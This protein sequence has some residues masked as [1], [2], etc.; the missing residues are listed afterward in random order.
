[1]SADSARPDPHPE[2]DRR[3]FSEKWHALQALKGPYADQLPA[4]QRAETR[5]L[6]DTTDGDRPVAW[7]ARCGA[8]F[9]AGEEFQVGPDGAAG[10]R[11]DPDGHR[12]GRCF[13]VFMRG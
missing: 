3:A 11:H 6:A 10:C 1:M 5:Y 4:I 13:A 8:P 7:C 9:F 12:I 2:L